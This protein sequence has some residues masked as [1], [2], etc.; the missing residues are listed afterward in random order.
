MQGD[1]RNNHE[2][3]QGSECEQSSKHGRG[4]QVYVVKRT[5]GKL[6]CIDVYHY[7]SQVYISQTMAIRGGEEDLSTI[8]RI[9]V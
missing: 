2:Q 5:P 8:M 7:A 1:N 9:Y 3:I 6:L 4:H